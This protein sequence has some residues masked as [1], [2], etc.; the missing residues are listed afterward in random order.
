MQLLSSSARTGISH[1]KHN[2]MRMEWRLSLSLAHT[3]THS[4][5]LSPSIYSLSWISLLLRPPVAPAKF[6]PPKKIR[7]W[8]NRNGAGDDYLECRSAHVCVC[9]CKRNG[10]FLPPPP[11]PLSHSLKGKKTGGSLQQCF[12][13]NPCYSF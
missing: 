12:D 2:G 9:V 4:S 5:T 10:F 1:L 3:L 7:V 13:P 8:K 11:F 6:E